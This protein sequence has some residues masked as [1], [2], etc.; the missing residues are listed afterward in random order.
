MLIL[1]V[2]VTPDCGWNVR[3]AGSKDLIQMPA[4]PVCLDTLVLAT[5]GAAVNLVSTNVWE[6]LSAN[7][8]VRLALAAEL[9]VLVCSDIEQ[10][11]L[12]SGKSNNILLRE[13]F[14]HSKQN[15]SPF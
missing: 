7:G 1:I 4:S 9:T 2:D 15:A 6:A 8:T 10:P 13:L 3:L 14:P 5:V 11:L 12:L